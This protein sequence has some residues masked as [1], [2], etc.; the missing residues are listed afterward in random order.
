MKSATGIFFPKILRTK[1]GLSELLSR[2][3]V[4]PIQIQIPHLAAPWA[5]PA[6]RV[7]AR[8]PRPM[9]PELACR[10]EAIRRTAAAREVARPDASTTRTRAVRR[11]APPMPGPAPAVPPSTSSLAVLAH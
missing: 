1:R 4:P 6:M 8:R 9:L 2:G 10:G 5:C 3:H 11:L 7:S